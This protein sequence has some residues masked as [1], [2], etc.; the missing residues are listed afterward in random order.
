MQK[1]KDNTLLFTLEYPPFKGGVASVYGNIVE[2]WSGEITVLTGDKLLKPHWLFALLRLWRAVRKNKARTVLVGHLLPLGTVTWLLAKI[3]NI[4]YTVF[5]H[6]MDFAQAVGVARKKKLARRIL[7]DAERIIAMNSYTAGLV[8]REFGNEIG[9]K[10]VV[11]NPGV[12]LEISNKNA[13][14]IKRL[15]ERYN[16]KNKIILLQVGRLVERKGVDK[17]LEAL[18]A[19]AKECPDLVY[20]IVGTGPEQKNYEL[21]IKNDELCDNVFLITDA[22]DAEV[23]AWYDLCDIFIMISREINGDFEGFG[24]VYLEANAH[25]KPVVAG[26]SGGVR[27]AV[28]NDLTGLLVNPESADEIKNAIIKLY[29]DEFL[30]RRLGQRGR[31]WV[32]SFEWR[33]QVEKMQKI[34]DLSARGGSALS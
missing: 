20:V 6:G 29:H 9:T 24:I 2:Y 21:R 25:G 14:I 8:Q 15:E 26:D 33:E 16:L 17:V 4:R 12:N 31:E 13:E 3:V 19:V 34:L 1:K 22:D 32:K 10:V 11:V 18:P 28:K 30:R 5:L 7:R 27:D 23:N